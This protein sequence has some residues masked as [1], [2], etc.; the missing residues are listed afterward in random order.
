MKTDTGTVRVADLASGM[1]K[2]KAFQEL[3][4]E[5]EVK[6]ILEEY[7]ADM[8]EEIDFEAFLRVS[9]LQLYL[10]K[11]FLQ[12][13]CSVLSRLINIRQITEVC[14]DISILAL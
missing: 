6:A 9:Y 8:E 5:K 11:V 4:T 14:G 1:T 7:Y 10:V 13:E 3:L 12:A 2:L